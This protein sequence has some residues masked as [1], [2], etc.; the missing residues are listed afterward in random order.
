MRVINTRKKGEKIL[1]TISTLRA[2]KAVWQLMQ[3]WWSAANLIAA[4]RHSTWQHPPTCLW[5]CHIFISSTYYPPPPTPH[6][7]PQFL[8]SGSII[9]HPPTTS[10]CL[11]LWVYLK[12]ETSHLEPA[13]CKAFAFIIVIISSEGCRGRKTEGVKEGSRGAKLYLTPIWCFCMRPWSLKKN[14]E[15]EPAP[16]NFCWIYIEQVCIW[17]LILRCF[18]VCSDT[19]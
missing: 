18:T 3:P 10:I 15:E 6:I 17:W 1:Q 2:A 8:L 9:L 12:Q 11:N 7:L 14:S 19:V 13:T 5:G 16:A 4:G